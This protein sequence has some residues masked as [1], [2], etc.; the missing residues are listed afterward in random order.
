M[1][2]SDNETKVDLLN[3]EAI[4]QT[5]IELLGERPDQPLTIGIHGDWGAG[6]SSVLEMIE[7]ALIDDKS[8]LCIKFNGWRFQGFEDAKI[9]LIEG[10]VTELVEKQP[11][12]DKA[13][14]AVKGIFRRINWLKIAKAGGNLALAAHGMP[15]PAII[16]A[17]AGRISG[18]SDDP[19]ELNDAI[20]SI[21][22]YLNPAQAHSAP[23]EIREFL[24][25]FDKLLDDAK[26]DQL[27]VLID[28]LDRCLPEIAIETLE[29]IRLF[30]FTSKTAFVVAAD[31]AMIEYAVRDHFPDLPESSGPQ[32]YA[33]NYL[34]KLIQ[35]PFRIPPLGEMET[36]YY[37]GL[38][39]IGAE[40]GESDADFANLIS[41]A[42]DRLQKP[43]ETKPLTSEDLA[44]TLKD[45]AEKAQNALVLADQLGP[46]LAHGSSGN[47]RQIKRFLNALLLRQSTAKAR[48]FSD[49]VKTPVLSKLMLAESFHPRLFDQ[50][51]SSAAIDPDGRCTDIAKFEEK[52]KGE[53]NAQDIS[54]DEEQSKTS[55]KAA[56]KKELRAAN[57]GGVFGE[58]RSNDAIRNWFSIAPSLGQEDLRPYLF[59]ARQEKDYFG[60]AALSGKVADLVDQLFNS[61]LAV[62]ALEEQLTNLTIEEAEQLFDATRGRI[63]N[64]SNFST[65]P[66]GIDGMIV[67]V[68]TQPHLQSRLIQLLAGLPTDGLGAWVVGGWEKA[69]TQTEM[70]Q[71]FADLLQKWAG[72][73]KNSMLS[74]SAKSTLT[75]LS[76]ER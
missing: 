73:A 55:K 2:L 54:S 29:A 6:K 76:S 7:S 60:S 31:E 27:V 4:A 39:L 37:V 16:D 59:V 57:D 43:W 69:L 49:E 3:N 15:P 1:I 28:D 52:M 70:K 44:G 21:P 56:A 41:V 20:S 45:K 18:M 62:Q 5:V 8:R 34:E 58:W 36:R 9:A 61:K 12:L 64:T 22:G 26:I 23:D 51:A 17:I 71:Q 65:K 19:E 32:T 68:R 38:L 74:G 25:A 42:R 13:G 30:V 63:L 53:S 40:L 24:E 47:P 50:I 75:M 72:C 10:I 67:L 66:A 46:S 33:R 48:G 14:D 11:L 35:V